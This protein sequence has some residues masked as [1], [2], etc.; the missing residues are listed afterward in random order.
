[1]T[2]GLKMYGMAMQAT[3]GNQTGD[4]PWFGDV[5]GGLKWESWEEYRGID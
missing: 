2:R 3:K 5:V 4:K 1:M